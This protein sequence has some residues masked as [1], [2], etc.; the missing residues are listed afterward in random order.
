MN[1]CL[2]SSTD[3]TGAYSILQGGDS[4]V[5]CGTVHNSRVVKHPNLHQTTYSQILTPPLD[6]PWSHPQT[7][8]VSVLLSTKWR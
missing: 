3:I 1:I 7:L 4:I 2:N 5:E 8:Q 6:R